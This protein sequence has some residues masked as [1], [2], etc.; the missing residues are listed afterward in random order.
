[1]PRLRALYAMGDLVA[2]VSAE[3][4]RA[5]R[6]TFGAEARRWQLLRT[7]LKVMRSLSP[8]E[9]APK[10]LFGS[11]R[12]VGFLGNGQTATNHQA[13]TWFLTHC[14]PEMRRRQPQLRLRLVGR[15]P[16]THS[17]AS[18]AW[19]C[20]AR[21]TPG[22][23]HCGW[24]W[25]TRYAGAEAAAG[26]DSLGFLEP[27]E[28]RSE[29]LSW[30]LMVAPIRATTGINTK[31]LVALELGIPVVATSAAAAPF[32]FGPRAART[33]ATTRNA[34]AIADDANS[35]TQAAL[36]LTSDDKR[37][38]AAV[39]AERSA[40]KTMLKTDPA[41]GDMRHVIGA[42]CTALT[43]QPYAAAHDTPGPVDTPGL[44]HGDL[45]SDV[46]ASIDKRS[47]VA[48]SI[49]GN[50]AAAPPPPPP[51]V[52]AFW[53][54]DKK[55]PLPFACKWGKC[56][57]CAI[58]F[59]LAAREGVALKKGV[60]G[61]GVESGGVGWE[62]LRVV[63]NGAR[64]AS[65]LRSRCYYRPLHPFQP[66]SWFSAPRPPPA[67]AAPPPALLLLGVAGAPL[68]ARAATLVRRVWW[69]LCS[70]C[71]LRCYEQPNPL[72][73]GGDGVRGFRSVT[74]D[75]DAWLDLAW[76]PTAAELSGLPRG[77]FRAIRFAHYEEGTAAGRAGAAAA[78]A[79][80]VA[81]AA[82]AAA[83][84]PRRRRSRRSSCR[85][86]SPC[87]AARRRTRRAPRP[88]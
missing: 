77:A 14:W 61:G 18:G 15:P 39:A 58:C 37:W 57:G 5:E 36:R 64:N 60:F 88:S 66:S 16:G 42:A 79:K 19:P 24:A 44:V 62:G 9:H 21:E 63:T 72:M 50:A 52:C 69:R 54:G 22:R 38:K 82:A 17:N 4:Q 41:L 10:R 83:A 80:A 7:P 75:A 43:A 11:T 86:R 59:T 6:L 45:V 46:I 27:A 28:M 26:I 30:R 29:V 65:R 55:N 8:G 1:M 78:G 67:G 48:P 53:C 32:G 25:G 2:H 68:P 73:K 40:F 85:C 70:H 12:H 76:A 56:A 51:A 74:N 34:M 81:A 84:P 71:H 47:A 87:A 49:G 33:N 35:F 23:P 20:D 3:D 13:I 31:L